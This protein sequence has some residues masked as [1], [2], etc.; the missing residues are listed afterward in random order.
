M[1]S[2]VFR[3]VPRLG[4]MEWEEIKERVRARYGYVDKL[5]KNFLFVADCVEEAW[6]S[7]KRSA[8]LERL[9]SAIVAFAQARS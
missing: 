4:S 7:G 8:N 5:D 9:C 2:R 6:N 1:R 3:F